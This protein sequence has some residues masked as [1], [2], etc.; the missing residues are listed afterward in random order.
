M[1][2]NQT[3]IGFKAITR[4]DQERKTADMSEFLV[5]LFDSAARQDK[6]EICLRIFLHFEPTMISNSQ[7]LFDGIASSMRAT[8]HF[9]EFK[10][11]MMEILL[12]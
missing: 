3:A 9:M 10:L 12:H 8:P 11:M 6:F 7:K 5:N 4:F 1:K 2:N